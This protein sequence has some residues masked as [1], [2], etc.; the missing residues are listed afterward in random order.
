MANIRQPEQTFFEKTVEIILKY[1]ILLTVLL[2]AI[3]II[4]LIGV[5][6]NYIDNANNEK[7]SRQFDAAEFNLSSLTYL[8]NESEK[9]AIYQQQMQ[10]LENLILSYPRTISAIRARLLLGR[11]Y[12][13]G[14][15]TSGNAQ[16]LEAAYTNYNFAYLTARTD[17]YKTLALLGRAES[18][19]QENKYNDAFADYSLVA[20]AYSNQ[21][22]AP[23]AIIGMARCRE[24]MSDTA[25]A[26]EYYTRVIKDYPESEWSRFARGKIYFYSENTPKTQPN[27][28]NA[29]F[30]LPR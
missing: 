22:F 6:M 14:F 7:A 1:R 21:G 4:I 25:G 5:T 11:F 28:T 26:I 30:I 24:Q 17:F 18:R 15:Y 3:V 12:F 27:D 29:Q 23:L 19:E 8:T 16:L 13:Q 20:S 10:G 9:N 2:T